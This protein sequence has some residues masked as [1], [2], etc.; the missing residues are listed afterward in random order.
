MPAAGPLLHLRRPLSF[1]G[2]VDPATGRITDPG[3]D[4]FD[5]RIGGT[6]LVIDVTR[7]S[8]SSSG[9]LLELIHRRLAP[10]AIGLGDPDAIL[11]V[12]ALAGAAMGWPVPP[13]FQVDPALLNDWP[14]GAPAQFDE[15]GAK[16]RIGWLQAPE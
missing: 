1:W 3:N 10:T 2:G 13:V 9:I 16:L 8:S 11:A 14:A 4:G 12:G 6:I 7:G 15:V 5:A